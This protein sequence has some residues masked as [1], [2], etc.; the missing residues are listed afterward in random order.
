MA[1]RPISEHRV[2]IRHFDGKEV[3]LCRDC[4]RKKDPMLAIVQFGHGKLQ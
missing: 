1:K 4:W 3:F 2:Y